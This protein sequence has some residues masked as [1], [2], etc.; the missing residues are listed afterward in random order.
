MEKKTPHLTTIA[1]FSSYTLTA[2]SLEQYV[3]GL[4]YFKWLILSQCGCYA[5]RPSID[6]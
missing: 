2:N 3:A 1:P 5:L 4:N 6:L